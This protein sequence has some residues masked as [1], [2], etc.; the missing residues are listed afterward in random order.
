MDGAISEECFHCF[1]GICIASVLKS[2]IT[3]RDQDSIGIA[4]KIE[5][6]R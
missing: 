2:E 6:L 5:E 4:V 3:D 1:F